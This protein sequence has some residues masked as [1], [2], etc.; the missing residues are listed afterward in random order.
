MEVTSADL[1][2]MI[3]DL[4]TEIR[5][6]SSSY[7]S[8]NQIIIV[9]MS[10]LTH[11]EHVTVEEAARIRR[12][13]QRQIRRQIAAGSL[14]LEI[15]PGTSESGIPLR[16]IH[17]GWIDIRTAKAALEREAMNAKERS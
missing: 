16:Q 9:L 1:A 6:L 13:T 2:S 7:A 11:P 4:R 8:A 10:R 14:S 5:Q 17:S 3:Q 12:V 15:I